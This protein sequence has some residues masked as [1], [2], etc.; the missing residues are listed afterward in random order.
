[1]KSGVR[2]YISPRINF[3]LYVVHY[4]KY[5]CLLRLSP[6]SLWVIQA[7]HL[8][9]LTDLLCSLFLFEYSRICGIDRKRTGRTDKVN[10]VQR[11]GISPVS[12]HIWKHSKSL[13]I[14]RDR[15][16]EATICCFSVFFGRILKSDYVMRRPSI[17]YSL[18]QVSGI[19]SILHHEGNTTF[20][21][22]CSRRQ[23]RFGALQELRL[24]R[25]RYCGCARITLKYHRCV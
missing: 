9:L 11:S 22:A 12:T 3:R 24:Q 7:S 23:H 13:C 5:A 25:R 4:I 14:R 16:I 10:L 19:V 20:L 8:S 6:Q 2:E 17:K 15:H 21:S 18:Q 1:M